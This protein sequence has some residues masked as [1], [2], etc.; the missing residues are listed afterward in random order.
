MKVENSCGKCHTL[1]LLGRN[2]AEDGIPPVDSLPASYQEFIRK[3]KH[4]PPLAGKDFLSRWRQKTVAE[5]IARFQVTASDSFFQFQNMNDD[6]VVNITAYALK[7]SGAK[8]GTEPLLR[9]NSTVVNSL[10][11]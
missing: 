11:P 7:V 8:A 10:I 4:V 1:T 3:S 5:R 2:S 9:T 6:T